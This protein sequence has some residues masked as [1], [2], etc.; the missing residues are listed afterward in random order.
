MDFSFALGG[1]G[2]GETCKLRGIFLSGLRNSHMI[3][4][5]GL[6][7]H[8]VSHML[9]YVSNDLIFPFVSRNKEL[10]TTSGHIQL[11]Y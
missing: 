10:L 2:R 11:Q 4:L 6:L 3:Q 9:L 7:S 8:R 1:G 5:I